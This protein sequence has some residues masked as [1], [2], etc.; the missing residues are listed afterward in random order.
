VSFATDVV[1][2]RDNLVAEFRGETARRAALVAAG[3]PPPATYSV[4]GRSVDWNN[5]MRLMMDEI[6][7]ANE[8]VVAVGGEGL[9]EEHIRGYT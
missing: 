2:I 6:R 5:Y 1:A 8:L 7:R 9:A 4:N 3:S